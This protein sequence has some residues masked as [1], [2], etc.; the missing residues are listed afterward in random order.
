LSIHCIR[1]MAV[2]ATWVRSS[3]IS[4]WPRTVAVIHTHVNS[5][6]YSDTMISSDTKQFNHAAAASLLHC[7]PNIGL[8]FF[9][10]RCVINRL[11]LMEFV[12]EWWLSCGLFDVQLRRLNT[13]WAAAEAIRPTDEVP[14]NHAQIH[15]ASIQ[16]PATWSLRLQSQS[17]H[18]ISFTLF[19]FCAVRIV[20]EI[21]TRTSLNSCGKFT[22]NVNS[23]C[24]VF[25]VPALRLAVAY[26]R[27]FIQDDN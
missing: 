6:K 3:P 1:P 21:N 9:Y 11:Q 5:C 23:P 25:F 27:Q 15:G 14:V 10:S 24:A 19:S 20:A 22:E 8:W 4:R 16:S 12:Q 17:L 26:V 13:G 18:R 2:R 7:M